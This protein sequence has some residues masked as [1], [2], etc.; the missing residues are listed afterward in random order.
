MSQLS[1]QFNGDVHRFPI[2]IYYEDTDSVG[3]VYHANYLKYAERARTEMLRLVG[4]SQTEMAL[5]YGVS[6]AVR[7][8]VLDFRGAAHLDDLIE[9]RSRL[10][11]MAAATASA[12][13]TIW[14]GTE[15][16]VRLSL[17]VVCLRRDG[18]PSRIPWPVRHALEPYIQRQKQV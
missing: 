8:C 2:R 9:V 16:L 18:R 17:R 4:I 7:D 11:Q 14:R 10:V 1:G 13:Q 15:E 5:R 6:F 12:A 3:L